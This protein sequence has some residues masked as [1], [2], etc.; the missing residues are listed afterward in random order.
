MGNADSK[1][2]LTVANILSEQEQTK[3]L[4]EQETKT[5]EDISHLEKELL[6]YGISRCEAS[7]SD[8]V[9]CIS[10]IRKPRFWSLHGAALHPNSK[11]V[12]NWL[13]V[14]SRY[15]KKADAIV[16]LVKEDPNQTKRIHKAFST[17]NDTIIKHSRFEEEELFK[18]F[19]ENAEKIDLEDN[20][21]ALKQQ[22][23]KL[24]NEHQNMH[25]PLHSDGVRSCHKHLNNK[26]EFEKN[27]ELLY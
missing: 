18:F 27:A 4:Q 23:E 11:R 17:L 24:G 10:V 8:L 2:A 16:E 5:D 1:T 12:A 14:H 19:R 21:V 22:L 13:W 3:I 26:V 7:D 25:D 15:R 6:R 20:G 9:K